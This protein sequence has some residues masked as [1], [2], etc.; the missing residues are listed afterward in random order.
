[1]TSFGVPS[2]EYPLLVIHF[3]NSVNLASEWLNLEQS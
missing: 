3:N 2:T 1:M